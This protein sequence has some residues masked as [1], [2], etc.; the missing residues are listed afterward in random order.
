[1]QHDNGRDN[2]QPIIAQK[3]FIYQGSGWSWLEVCDGVAS[4][5]WKPVK[6][7]SRLGSD[8]A[9]QPESFVFSFRLNFRAIAHQ[10]AQDCQEVS[11]SIFQSSTRAIDCVDWCSFGGAKY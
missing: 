4:C 11:I 2:Q 7:W 6:L 10:K 3:D 1:M 5:E 8:K 9:H